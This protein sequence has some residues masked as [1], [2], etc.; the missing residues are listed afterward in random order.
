MHSSAQSSNSNFILLTS[1][2]SHGSDGKLKCFI[3]EQ[4]NFN[5]FNENWNLKNQEKFNIILTYILG[6]LQL[7]FKR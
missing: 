1:T 3:P 2:A 4:S 5:K 6:L 7:A